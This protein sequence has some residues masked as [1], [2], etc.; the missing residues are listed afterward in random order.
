MK[1]KKHFNM[2][3]IAAHTEC[4]SAMC[5]AGHTLELAGYKM[6]LKD[7]AD[8]GGRIY[9][10]RKDYEFISPT[11]GQTVKKP[12]DDAAKELGLN[13]EVAFFLFHDFALTNPGKAAKRIEKMIAGFS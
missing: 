8:K 10:G 9:L 11:T 7:N 6:R 2:R 5:I 13:S 3:A 12:L 1:H 4:G